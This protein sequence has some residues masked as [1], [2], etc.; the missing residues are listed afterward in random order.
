MKTQSEEKLID[1]ALTGDA[2][3]F[4]ELVVKYY[5]QV[6]MRLSPCAD[7]YFDVQDIVQEAFLIAWRR[8]AQLK[9]KRNFAAWV[10]R[11][12]VNLSKTWHRRQCVQTQFE[13]AS[14]ALDHQEI[15]DDQKED[16]LIIKTQVR[17]A[18]SALSESHKDV[19]RHYYFN[20]R[21]YEETAAILNIN[22][23][24]V[25]SRL[26]K[27]R[28]K[29]R[30]EMKHMTAKAINRNV[31]ELNRD[32]LK[33]LRT[34]A[35]LCATDRPDKP[36]LAGVLLETHGRIVATDGR[37]LVAR[38]SD[39]F[40]DLEENAVIGGC[41]KI[42]DVS[43]ATLVLGVDEAVLRFKGNEEVFPVIHGEFPKYER[44]FP[45]AWH[46][47]IRIKSSDFSRL[48]DEIK[49]HLEPRHPAL[50][51][52]RYTPVVELFI[53]PLNLELS[54]TIGKNMGYSRLDPK[55]KA[56][57]NSDQSLD[58]SHNSVIKFSA[59]NKKSLMEIPA[60]LFNFSYISN[61]ITALCLKPDEMIE[62][63]ITDHAETMP[64]G[65]FSASDPEQCALIMPIRR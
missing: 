5:R 41:L 15:H 19:I 50:G 20:N 13:D 16:D 54:I 27:A 63:R 44:V 6:Y 31:F 2:S 11:I 12:A 28:V 37:V 9:D 56:K 65:I 62:F 39:R 22:V 10:C 25:R 33:T 7:N 47:R 43:R 45:K 61:A 30:K 14:G 3:A 55:S 24:S 36:V 52:F 57:I 49:P 4:N 40:A 32:D 8:L 17:S 46:N 29:L 51:G 58:W 1:S 21:S 26:Q 38:K 23:N 59:R 34:A 60:M 42:P 48:A 18:Y 64:F 35:A 53:N